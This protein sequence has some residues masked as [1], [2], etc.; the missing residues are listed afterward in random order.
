MKITL[1]AND[2]HIT[3]ELLEENL[4]ELICTCGEDF[5]IRREEIAELAKK[6][7]VIEKPA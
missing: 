6:F 3:A 7:P 1:D 4:I 5:Q 2:G